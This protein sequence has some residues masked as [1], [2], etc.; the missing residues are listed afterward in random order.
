M[1]IANKLPP[2]LL[3]KHIFFKRTAI[4][5][6]GALNKKKKLRGALSMTSV[7]TALHVR[8]NMLFLQG[9][10]GKVL[11][12]LSIPLNIAF[13]YTIPD[14]TKEKWAEWYIVTFVVSIIWIG[15]TSYVMV[16]FAESAF[17]LLLWQIVYFAVAIA[18]AH[19]YLATELS[20]FTLP[21]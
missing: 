8:F 10:F 11:S 13:K 1:L 21:T 16:L 14:C 18:C 20:R 6:G 4:S 3:K 2:P 9:A 19:G 15:A 5:R 17:L 7:F 12:I